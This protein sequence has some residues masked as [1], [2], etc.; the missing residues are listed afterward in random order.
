MTLKSNC[1]PFLMDERLSIKK[2]VSWHEICAQCVQFVQYVV[3][4]IEKRN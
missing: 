3:E 1:K 4:E 2:I